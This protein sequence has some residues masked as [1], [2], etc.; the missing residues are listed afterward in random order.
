MVE[1]SPRAAN[2]TGPTA[3][4]P[5]HPPAVPRSRSL[6]RALVEAYPGAAAEARAHLVDWMTELQPLDA[7]EW[8]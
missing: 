4:E 1:R 8:T 7:P 6:L 5:A 3:E 2:A